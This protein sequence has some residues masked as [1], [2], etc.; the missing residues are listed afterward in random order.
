MARRLRGR[1]GSPHDREGENALK[2][3][4]A[5]LFYRVLNTLSSIPIP[6]D[7][8]DFRV[9]DRYVAD[10]VLAMPERDRFLRGMI[11][12]VGFRQ[13][14][15]P[16]RRAPRFA[17]TTRYPVVKIL[18]FARDGIFSFSVLP[19][20]LATRLGLSCSLLAIFGAIVGF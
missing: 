15:V 6:L 18:R 8:G 20:R 3:E 1:L 16:Y 4:T 14:A 2:K 7:S 11:T 5:K 17:G 9:I 19:P 12:W 13:V 10:A